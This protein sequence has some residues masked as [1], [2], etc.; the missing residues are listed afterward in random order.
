MEERFEYISMAGFD[1]RRIGI[2]AKRMDSDSIEC[3]YKQS[4]YMSDKNLMETISAMKMEP[5]KF[6]YLILFA[7][8]Y[9]IDACYNGVEVEE[10]GY[11]MMWN[12]IERGRQL[13][14]GEHP[15]P[16]KV[17][18]SCTF[19][20]QSR[21]YKI[22][23]TDSIAI[24]LYWIHRGMIKANTTD[25]IWELNWLIDDYGTHEN[26]RAESASVAIWCF[27]TI[28][29]EFFNANKQFGGRAKRNSIISLN[30]KALVSQLIYYFKLS[31][32]E[33]FIYSDETLKGFLRQY[34]GRKF[35]E[36]GRIYKQ[37]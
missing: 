21:N 7:Y 2:F 25:K 26:T 24:L 29:L 19:H 30:K 4:A 20:L 5:E 8:D 10:G 28:I 34:R 18:A 35:P 14:Y 32:N 36:E 37:V 22:M 11:E 23:E 31:R 27:A 3:P 17:D 9:T 12:L 33:N 15:D 16:L 1:A 6:W 13:V